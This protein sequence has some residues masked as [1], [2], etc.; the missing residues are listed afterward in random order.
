MPGVNVSD[1]T[2]ANVGTGRILGPVERAIFEKYKK[3][4]CD[5]IPLGN[6]AIDPIN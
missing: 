6:E 5:N 1:P 4:V 2:K 3:K